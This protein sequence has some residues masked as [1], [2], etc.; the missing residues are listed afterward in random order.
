MDLSPRPSFK[1]AFKYWHRLGWVSFGGPVAQVAMMHEDLVEKKRWIDEEQYRRALT[2]CT[3]LPGPEAQQL[4]TYLGWVLHGSLG[5][6]CAGLLFIVPSVFILLTFA[7]LFVHFG[8]LN[9]ISSF[10]FGLKPAV[11]AFISLATIKIAKKNLLQDKQL[12]LAIAAFFLALLHVSYIVIFLGAMGIG[13]MWSRTIQSDYSRS[14]TLHSLFNKQDLYYVLLV[15]A[16]VAF[17]WILPITLITMMHFQAAWFHKLTLFFTGTALFSFGGAYTVLPYVWSG[18]T[19]KHWLTNN[20]MISALA[21][22]ETTPGPLIMVVAF[23][24]FLATW[25]QIHPVD[26]SQNWFALVGGLIAVWY[27][28]LP[29]FLGV[30]LGAPLVERLGGLPDFKITFSALFSA[31]VGM[32]FLLVLRTTGTMLHA[33]HWQVDFIQ[34]MIAMLAFFLLWKKPQF[35][36][37][38]VV[39]CC[40][41]VG[42]FV[43]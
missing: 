28:F 32:M 11:F 16:L 9:L 14:L 3:L 37:W 41:L 10:L 39:I 38:A 25:N 15:M 18:V 31:V 19:A 40:G 27:T 35:P 7:F 13:Y 12:W 33:G 20:E 1:E 21:L 34:L 23:V 36:V 42:I 2:L 30:F 29:S 24:G 5:G 8:Q 26:L 6:L 17:S 43:H 4:A 22:G